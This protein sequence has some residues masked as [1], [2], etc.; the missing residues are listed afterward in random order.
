M[1]DDLTDINI[2]L[3]RS[4]S[5]Q[6]VRT[7]TIGG[8]NTFLKSQKEAAGEATLTLAQ[9]DDRYET[10]HD[11]KNIQDIPELTMETFIPRGWTA[12][13]DAIGRT[14]NSTGARLA[15]MPEEERPGRVIFVILTDG[16]E[17]Y[18]KEFKKEQ[19]NEMIEHQ[20]DVYQWD[21]VFL[22]AN[23]DA[24]QTGVG[25]GILA[26]NSMTY[27]ATASG[28]CDVYNSIGASMSS[29]RVGNAQLKKSFFSNEDR[30]K[31]E[32]AGA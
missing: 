32:D 10:V 8:F 31:Q 9:F 13:L 4:G 19:I 22:G 21:F 11:G 3:D 30:K 17:N 29:Y 7:D 25:M 23:Q 28:V 14:I 27:A 2:V 20:T 12:L 1:R 24:I 26:G 5:M 18:S 16:Y 15:A 6:S